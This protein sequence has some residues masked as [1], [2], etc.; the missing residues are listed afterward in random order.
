MNYNELV[1]R[2]FFQPKHVGKLDCLL[3]NI[4]CCNLS[5]ATRNNYF[6]LFLAYNSL[7]R[8]DKVC[9]KAYG[10]PYLIAALEWVCEQLEGSFIKAHP[11]LTY[12]MLVERLEIPN[13][14]YPIAILVEKGYNDIINAVKNKLTEERHE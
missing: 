11:Q 12:R 4:I 1:E 6:N 10:S 3:P 2:Y 14:S 9:F 13:H 5:D 8:I 7:G